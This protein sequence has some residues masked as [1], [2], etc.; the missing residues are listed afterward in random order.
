MS[1]LKAIYNTSWKDTSDNL[2]NWFGKPEKVRENRSKK[3][4]QPWIKVLLLDWMMFRTTQRYAIA[5]WLSHSNSMKFWPR[6][7]LISVVF[8]GTTLS[9]IQHSPLLW[10]RRVSVPL[11]SA[12]SSIFP[13]P[14]LDRCR[15]GFNCSKIFVFWKL[16][17]MVFRV[18][19]KSTTLTWRANNFSGRLI[20]LLF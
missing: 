1:V 20:P 2:G 19:T 16:L 14:S 4:W 13:V 18:P 11:E 5:G 3:K 12:S 8:R 10:T 7:E 6:E 15:L 17:R 9:K